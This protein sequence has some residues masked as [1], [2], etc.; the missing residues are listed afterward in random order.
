MSGILGLVAC[1]GGGVESR[2]RVELA[3]RA[4][5]LGWRLAI[6]MTPTAATWFDAAGETEKLQALTDLPVR[7]APRM[8][9]E[10]K[11][12]P[13][14]DAFIVV[15]CTANSVAKLAT[16]IADNQALTS[17]GEALG[18]RVPMVLRPQA[19]ERQRAHPRWPRHIE[20]LESAGVKVS[21][22][23]TGQSWSL[24]LNELDMLVRKENS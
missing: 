11:P 9:G 8:P 23:V 6:T 4:K 18:A 24:L 10:P 22:P 2:F 17:L 21:P 19:D 20:V 1:A 14:P 15:P 16:G 7:S 12:Y 5:E 13:M 3:E